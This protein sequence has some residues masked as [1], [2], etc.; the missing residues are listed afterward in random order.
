MGN[1]RIFLEW[2]IQDE[3]H[4]Y[5]KTQLKEFFDFNEARL[6]YAVTSQPS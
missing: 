2:E 5:Q 3:D 1:S 6:D 4:E